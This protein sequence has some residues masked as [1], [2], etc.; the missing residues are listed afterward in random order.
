[1]KNNYSKRN[2]GLT[3]KEQKTTAAFK[4]MADKVK[5]LEKSLKSTQDELEKIRGKYHEADKSNAVYS[6]KNETVIFHEI[7]KFVVSVVCGG[8]GVNMITSGDVKNGVM[9]I[10]LG[11]I[12]YSVI[13]ISDHPKK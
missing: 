1:M 7:L 5:T 4:M 6:S 12:I 11:I 8:I 3:T 10:I 13:V 2:N 9:V